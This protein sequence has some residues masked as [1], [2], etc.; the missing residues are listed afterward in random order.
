[1][2]HWSGHPPW[3]TVA[4]PGCNTPKHIPVLLSST[5]DHLD[6][7]HQQSLLSNRQTLLSHQSLSIEAAV[8]SSHTATW[9]TGRGGR[10]VCA[11]FWFYLPISDMPKRRKEKRSYSISDINILNSVTADKRVGQT[12][13]QIHHFAGF[14]I[15]NTPS[16]LCILQARF[17][18]AS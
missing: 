14:E 4:E 11:Y 9:S 5:F 13:I 8:R 15:F 6:S 3:R 16:S 17:N 7:P 12:E 18:Q 1:M 2:L 10:G